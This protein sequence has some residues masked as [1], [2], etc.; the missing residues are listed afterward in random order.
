MHYLNMNIHLKSSLSLFHFH[1]QQNRQNRRQV[2]LQ[3]RAKLKMV[4][5]SA[6]E[7]EKTIQ[8]LD[9]YIRTNFSIYL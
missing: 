8:Q 4:T 1:S 5:M 3:N 7:L 2:N 9:V 6:F